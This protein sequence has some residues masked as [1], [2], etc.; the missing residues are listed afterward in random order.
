MLHC[1]ADWCLPLDELGSYASKLNLSLQPAGTI[2]ANAG[3]SFEDPGK[4]YPRLVSGR[5]CTICPDMY[6][7]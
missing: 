5:S 6:V 7:F 1:Q 3:N 4:R 2:A